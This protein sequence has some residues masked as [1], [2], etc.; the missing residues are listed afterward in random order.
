MRDRKGADPAVV[1]EVMAFEAAIAAGE[2]T[3]T[4]GKCLVPGCD[5]GDPG[6]DYGGGAFIYCDKHNSIMHLDFN[7]NTTKVKG[8]HRG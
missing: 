4:P 1:L 6:S 3:F 8:L 7:V 5:A 2:V